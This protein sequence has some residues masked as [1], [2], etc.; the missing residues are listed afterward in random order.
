MCFSLLTFEKTIQYD[1]R[2]PTLY[3]I[4]DNTVDK[5]A[6]SYWLLYICVIKLNYNLTDYENESLMILDYTSYNKIKN[7]KTKQQ[8][9]A[10]GLGRPKTK[11]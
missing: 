1:K 11:H 2:I 6:H 3:G 4:L 5:S 9:K 10:G 7:G 8:V